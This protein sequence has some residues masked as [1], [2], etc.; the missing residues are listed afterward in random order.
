MARF[1]LDNY[2]KVLFDI[3]PETNDFSLEDDEY[4]RI[5]AIKAEN[6]NIILTRFF[7][8]KADIEE[9]VK[10]YFTI[11]PTPKITRNAVKI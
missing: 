1:S 6:D 11:S 4:I 7:K 2:F 8:H 10:K 9:F 5:V 3:D